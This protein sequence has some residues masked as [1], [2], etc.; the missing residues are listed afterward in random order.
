MKTL[1]IIWHSRTGYARQMAQAL[2]RGADQV[3]HELELQAKLRV[4]LQAAP[5]T[6]PADILAADG[7]LFCAPENLASLTGE[8]KAC[9]DRCYYPVLDQI[10]GRPYA[11]AI[12]AGTDGEGAA[13]Q[14]TRIATGWRLRAV[15]APLIERNGAQTPD[16]ILAPKTVP[17]QALA[18]CE[19][20]GGLLAATLLTSET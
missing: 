16:A 18:R 9:L 10:A 8:M 19:E 15:A 20:L 6:D 13:R 2:A 1:L 7:Y 4:R 14:L 12:S 17:P 3:A 5:D 11:A